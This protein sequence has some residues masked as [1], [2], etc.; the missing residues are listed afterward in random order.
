MNGVGKTNLLDAIYYMAFG[1]SFYHIPDRNLIRF[2]MHSEGKEPFFRIE[3]KTSTEQE[4]AS[5]Y[6]SIRK[7]QATQN[8]VLYDRI[9]YHKDETHIDAI[10]HEDWNYIK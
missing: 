7:K 1:K 9:S 2:S 6:N 3:R 5:S 8:R 4:F 10:Y